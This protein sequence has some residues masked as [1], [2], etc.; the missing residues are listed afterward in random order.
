MDGSAKF[1]HWL[2]NSRRSKNQ[3]STIQRE[4]RFIEDPNKIEQIF[5]NHFEPEY[6]SPLNPCRHVDGLNWDHISIDQVA[7]LE[8]NF[9][10]E[11]IDR[12]ILDMDGEKAL[13]LD[14]FTIVFFKNCWE[15]VKDELL[16][17]FVEFFER[18]Y[19][20]EHE[21]DFHCLDLE[22]GSTHWT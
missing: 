20:H 21:F 22:K 12:A 2:A 15:V 5:V 9:E 8:G 13:G 17:A 10:E 14:G 7:W 3:I 16:L 18:C 6:G 19:Q 11:E 1:F 4:G